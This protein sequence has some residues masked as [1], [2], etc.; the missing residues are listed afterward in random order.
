MGKYYVESFSYDFNM[1]MPHGKKQANVIELNHKKSSK[2]TRRNFKLHN[3]SAGSL[4]KIMIAPVILGLIIGNI[5]LRVQVNEVT[6]EINKVRTEY[7]RALAE[8]VS[9]EMQVESAIN[10]KN[11]EK[12]AKSLGMQKIE[13][14]QI[15]F[16][17]LA[18]SDKVE[19][20]DG[21]DLVPLQKNNTE[22]S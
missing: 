1:F 15:N 5:Y 16:V 14:Y 18:V 13:P 19:I 20:T 4:L 17:N 10:Y 7:N 3:F 8:N 6:A 11:L 22:K 9:L 12:L 21:N 2:T